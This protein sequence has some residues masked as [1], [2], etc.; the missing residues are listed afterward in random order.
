MAAETGRL[1]GRGLTTVVG[2]A[3]RVQRPTEIV[4]RSCG[5]QRQ[6]GFWTHCPHDGQ[7]LAPDYAVGANDPVL[8]DVEF[9]LRF[10]SMMPLR[11]SRSCREPQALLSPLINARGF[12]QK[13]GMSALWFKD[14]TCLPT[15]TTKARMAAVSLAYLLEC[16]VERFVVASTAN[17]TNAMT[18]LIAFYPELELTAFAGREFA[19]RH[20]LPQL[21]NVRLVVVDGDFVSA[22]R[23]AKKYA[24]EQN[25]TWE[26]GFFNPARRVG[27]A[28]AYVEACA[29]LGRVPDWYFQAISSGMGLVAAGEF[30][31]CQRDAGSE[32]T[33]PR[34]VAVQQESCAPMVQAFREGCEQIQSHHRIGNPRGIA[35]AILR[36]D[37]T[38]S[39]PYVREHVV[40]SGGDIVSVTE[41]QILAA[42]AELLRRY[43]IH[44]G[45]SAAAALAAALQFG[46]TGRIAPD[47][48]VLVNV[49][50]RQ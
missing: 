50:G 37:P 46:A 39:Y 4:C 3:G 27:L 21:P 42:Q 25:A 48:V 12:G 26:G 18:R 40:A 22:E 8:E 33:I 32:S 6:A 20:T 23:A 11:D 10:R 43:G 41:L 35:H 15:A 49:S 36:G 5:W 38:A 17:S 47:D 45:A 30:A 31:A 29:Q 16:G 1:L 34:L 24:E 13:T 2:G 44:A 9:G 19:D 14:E 7:L 28:T